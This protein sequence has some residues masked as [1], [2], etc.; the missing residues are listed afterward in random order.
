M[1]QVYINYPNPKIVVH[2]NGTCNLIGMHKK[3][4]QRRIR[5]NIASLSGEL[6]KFDQKVY[7]FG[8]YPAA[9]DMWIEVDFSDAAFELAVLAYI[10]V[11]IGRHY[12][13]L[14]GATID[15]HC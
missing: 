1:I 3:P 4:G 15:T 13:P 5:L 11:L 2:S 14:A 10:Q 8:A 12:L 7:V 9:N 6:Q